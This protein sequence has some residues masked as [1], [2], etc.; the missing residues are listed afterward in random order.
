MEASLAQLR[1]NGLEVEAVMGYDPRDRSKFRA[2]FHAVALFGRRPGASVDTAACSQAESARWERTP[3]LRRD[4]PVDAEQLL[5]IG[6]D[7]FGSEARPF[8]QLLELGDRVLA[9]NFGMDG[10]AGRKIE[11]PAGYVHELRVLALQVHLD[12]TED[13]VVKG[14]VAEALH[15]EISRELA[16]DPVQQVEVELRRDALGIGVGGVQSGLVLLEIH[17]DQ[18]DP[19]RPRHLARLPQKDERLGGSEVADGGAG[20]KH[21]L[22]ADRHPYELGQRDGP[23]MVGADADDIEEGEAVGKLV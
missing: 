22:P 17:A 14:L 23:R 6:P 1:R 19:A 2:A 7:F 11:P 16:I 12:A 4:H 20:K 3:T 5:G 8:A 13:R 10:F 21:R 15:L 9:G 18:K